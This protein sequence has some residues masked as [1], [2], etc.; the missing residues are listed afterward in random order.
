MERELCAFALFT[1]YLNIAPMCLHDAAR[2]RESQTC[3]GAAL[4]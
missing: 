4:A 3:A 1:L 2:D